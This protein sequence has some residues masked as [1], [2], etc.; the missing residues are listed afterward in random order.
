VVATLTL[1]N[2]AGFIL[3]GRAVHTMPRTGGFRPNPNPNSGLLAGYFDR[4]TGPD[5]E[6]TA[7][8]AVRFSN[9][10]ADLGQFGQFLPVRQ[11]VYY[12]PGGAIQVEVT[13]NDPSFDYLG[14]EVYFRGSKVYQPGILPCLTYPAGKISTEPFILGGLVA[15]LPITGTMLNNI[16][17]AQSDSDMV[18]R[19]INIG[20]WGVADQSGANN[21][22]QY[23]QLY[24]QFKDSTGKTYSNLPVHVD[25]CFGGMGSILSP[26]TFLPQTVPSLYGPYHPPLLLPE[27][28]LPANQILYYD[29]YRQDG[30]PISG[31]YS[32]GT[33]QPVDVLLAFQGM[34]V[35]RQS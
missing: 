5:S 33:L 27:I 19:A 6:Y 9:E 18:I 29:L 24:V 7:Q 26:M 14:L 34:K 10:N 17:Q 3:R 11:P 13:N 8:Q 30:A 35:Y 4:F 32:P 22:P 16:C 31:I 12:P 15:G 21:Q 23:F 25:V 2:D 1:D 28:Y 20:S